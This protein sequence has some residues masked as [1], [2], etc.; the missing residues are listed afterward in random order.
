[1]IIDDHIVTRITVKRAQLD[2]EEE[3]MEKLVVDSLFEEARRL[4]AKVEHLQ[5]ACYVASEQPKDD[6]ESVYLCARFHGFEQAEII[7][8]D[9]DGL[10]MPVDPKA[11]TLR[12][13]IEQP[14]GGAPA[15][16]TDENSRWYERQGV[17]DATGFWAFVPRVQTGMRTEPR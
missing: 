10:R 7:G 15:E 14:T 5:A 2:R 13:S 11:K 1:M 8:G 6:P 17:S 3:R 12:V 4:G 9:H 16:L